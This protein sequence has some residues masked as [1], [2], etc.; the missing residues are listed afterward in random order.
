MSAFSALF[1]EKI[2]GEHF[3]INVSLVY[4]LKRI[5]CFYFFMHVE[6]CTVLEEFHPAPVGS[7]EIFY[8]F[9]NLLI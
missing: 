7:L 2:S 8:H 1:S 6:S 9:M 5:I 4:V 3:G